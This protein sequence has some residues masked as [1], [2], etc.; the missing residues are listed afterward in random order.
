MRSRPCRRWITALALAGAAVAVP[1]AA[2]DWGYEEGIAHAPSGGAELY[3]EQHWIRRHDGVALERVTLYRCPGGDAFARKQV[4]YRASHTAPDFLLE[5]RRGGYR[6]GLRRAAGATVVFVRPRA[7]APE[8]TRRLDAG[9]AA[10]LVADAGF[11]EFVRAHWSALAAGR[12]V[13][14]RF[15]VPSRL[16]SLPF[17]LQRTAT[18]RVAGEPAWVLRLQVD[19]MLGWIAPRIDVSYGQHSRRLLRF[20]GLT[21]LRDDAGEAQLRARI[22]FPTPARAVDAASA[23]QAAQQPLAVC[24]TGQRADRADAA[25]TV[26]YFARN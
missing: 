5:D 11:D 16:R 3:R 20:E 21:N 14:L 24:R 26:V 1:A 23:R 2:D 25:D 17:S 4:D 18:A 7:G 9:D 10:G 6:E 22:D 15:A 13:A 8:S 19:G 12:R